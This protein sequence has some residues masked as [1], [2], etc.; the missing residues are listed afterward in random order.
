MTDGAESFSASGAALERGVALHNRFMG[1]G[2]DPKMRVQGDM[3]SYVYVAEA[4]EET[5]PALPEKAG[6]V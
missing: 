3:S 2:Y 5:K 4:E 1:T 6:E